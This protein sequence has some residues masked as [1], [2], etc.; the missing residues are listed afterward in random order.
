MRIM[1][2]VDR[3]YTGLDVLYK[4]KVIKLFVKHRGYVVK[5]PN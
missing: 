1:D 4:L 3:I 2:S 5:Q